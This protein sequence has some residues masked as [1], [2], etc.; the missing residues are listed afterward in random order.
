MNV[1]P[2]A[3][4]ALDTWPAIVALKQSP[5]ALASF[6]TM[7]LLG[8]ALLIGT[9]IA[10]DLRVL[11]W[12]KQIEVRSLS[13]HLLPLALAALVLIVPSG[14]ALFAVEASA[15]LESSALKSKL[16]LLFAA[17]CLAIFFRAS[18]YKGAEGWNREVPAPGLARSCAG[19]SI[20]CWLGV[21]FFAATLGRGS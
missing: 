18:I 7:H 10:F 19:A 17:A 6:K 15:L 12:N 11:G 16:A 2:I 14:V 5:V 20:I 1:E 3:V 21:L 9:V 13:R 8:A 4:P